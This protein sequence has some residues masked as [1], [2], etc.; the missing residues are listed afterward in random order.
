M[1]NSFVQVPPDSTGKEI[2]T[3]TTAT[4][5]YHRQG[6]VIGDPSVDANVI[7]ISSRLRLP[8]EL[9]QQLDYDTGGGT[10][11]VSLVGIALPASGGPV[12]GGTSTNPLQVGDAGGSLTVDGPLTDVQLRASAVPISAASLPLPTGAATAAN[13]QTDALT[14]AELRAS[15][16]PV[17][18]ASLPLPTGAATLA[19]QQSQT[20]ALQIIDDWDESDR[21][22]VNPIVGQAGVA[23]GTGADA[24]NVQ[25]VSLATDIPLPTGSNIIGSVGIN[26]TTPGTTDS[27]TVKS[28]TVYQRQLFGTPQTV[29]NTAVDIA[30]GNF[31]GAPAASYDNTSDAAYPYAPYAVAMAEFPDWAA[32]PVDGTVIELWGVLLDT[33]G[34]EDDTNAPAT[35][36]IGGG[37]YFGC[38]RIAP[39]DSLQ[40]RTITIPMDGVGKVD[41]YLRNGTAQN[42]NNDAGTN[43]VVKVTPLTI[44][45]VG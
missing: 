18:A 20:T 27:V 13:Q 4:L 28:K 30:A 29:I 45:M 25:R 14:D 31:S 16:V 42:M 38:W 12:A 36:V 17:S 41:F 39:A 7:P 22:K 23:G 43:C 2:D 6:I 24:A 34:T 37:R 35:T 11:L 8:V 19:E 26:Q 3:W 5:G 10:A 9:E 33:D 21:A 1:A 40:R 15:A 44:G 32:A